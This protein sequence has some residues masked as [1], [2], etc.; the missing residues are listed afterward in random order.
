MSSEIT[1]DDSEVGYSSMYDASNTAQVMDI[2]SA[3]I[4]VANAINSTLEEEEESKYPVMDNAYFKKLFRN[5]P[6]LYYAT[7]EINDI[8][9]IQ[10]VGFR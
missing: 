6:N 10:C 5:N 7:P 4:S 8:L 3:T 9:Y 2:G 1:Q